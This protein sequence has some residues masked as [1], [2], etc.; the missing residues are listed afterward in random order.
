MIERQ[1]EMFN[2]H[3]I[4]FFIKK[5]WGETIGNIRIKSSEIVG[6]IEEKRGK[7]Y[8]NNRYIFIKGSIKK[9]GTVCRKKK[10]VN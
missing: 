2:L 10:R 4:S 5:L 1:K 9:V 8:N 3:N 7:M 6:N